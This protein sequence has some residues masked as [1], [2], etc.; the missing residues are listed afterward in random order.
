MEIDVTKFTT[1][2]VMLF[3]LLALITYL[4]ALFLGTWAG[5]HGF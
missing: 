3:P 4:L 1:I 2:A 5:S